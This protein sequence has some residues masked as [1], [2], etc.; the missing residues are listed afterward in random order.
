MNKYQ[1]SKKIWWMVAS[2]IPLIFGACA[3]N[4]ASSS[5]KQ[6]D[7]GVH[8]K[9]PFEAGCPK[10]DTDANDIPAAPKVKPGNKVHFY[11][12]PPKQDFYI[13]FSPFHKVLKSGDGEKQGKLS[14]RVKPVDDL[15]PAK[16]NTQDSYTYTVY[17]EGCDPVDPVIIIDR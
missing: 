17:A 9:V 7:G 8:V 2:L 1:N 13:A 4:G 6:E 3:A 16:P 14:K 5:A 12:D 15:P 11:S 10:L